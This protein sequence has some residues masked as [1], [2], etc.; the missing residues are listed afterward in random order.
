VFTFTA[1]GRPWLNQQ[2]GAQIVF[3]SLYRA[4]SW[5][6]IA[7]TR[8]GV[9]AV[10]FWLLYLACRA[11]GAGVRHAAWLCL[12]ALFV[13]IDGFAPRP[14]LIA[15]LLFALT[16]AIVASRDRH[17]SM[18]WLVPPITLIWA[19]VHGSFP[20]APVVL[21]LAWAEERRG[22][23]RI[24]RTT[25]LVALAAVAAANVNPYGARIWSYVIELST[26]PEIRRTIEEWQPPSV[27][28]ASGFAFFA[29]AAAVAVVAIRSRRRLTWPRV[30]GL[31]LFFVIG[32]TAIRGVIWWSLA[33]P[34]LLADLLSERTVRRDEPSRLNSAVA[35]VLVAIGI[36]FLPWFRPTFTSSAD[37]GSADGLLGYAPE[38]YSSRVRVMVEPGTRLFVPELWASWFELVAP[39]DPVMVDP[40]IE[41]F[42]SEIWNDYDA[43]SNA[44]DGWE[45]VADR[46]DIRVLVLSRRQQSDLIAVVRDDPGWRVV[47][48]D[49]DG[50]LLVRLT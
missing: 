37:S 22:D 6:L 28:T 4:G 2:W 7:L 18:L 40:R 33:A 49:G 41:L 48:E 43:I 32:A 5:E 3:A 19:N 25:L 42:T 24:A 20:L 26:N 21:L 10:S 9:V 8:A 11:R 16:L 31:A 39:R 29:S 44:T 23:P 13:S 36:V 12:G 14:Q 17:P 27:T 35:V 47:Y 30:A 15:F 1:L 38:A 46:W 50:L 34:V 45:S